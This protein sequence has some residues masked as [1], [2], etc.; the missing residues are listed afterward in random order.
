V[1]ASG[2]GRIGGQWAIDEFTTDHWITIQRHP[3]YFPI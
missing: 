3:R 2:I 1:R